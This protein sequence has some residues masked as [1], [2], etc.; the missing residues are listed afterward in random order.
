MSDD[1]VNPFERGLATMMDRIGYRTRKPTGP[2]R[3]IERVEVHLS[4]RN[5]KNEIGNLIIDPMADF[6]IMAVLV[7]K[8]LGQ[9]ADHWPTAEPLDKPG[10]RELYDAAS[11]VNVLLFQLRRD[12]AAQVSTQRPR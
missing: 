3:H 7:V 11:L 4:S 6:E 5:E 1:Y 9:I 2:Y 12:R 10:Q 8:Y